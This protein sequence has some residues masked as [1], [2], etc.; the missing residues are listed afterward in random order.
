MSLERKRALRTQFMEWLYNATEGAEVEFADPADFVESAGSDPDEVA[1]AIRYLEGESLIE[2]LWSLGSGL[3]SAVRITH[4]GVREVEQALT[5][6][7]QPTQHFTPMVNITHIHGDVTGSQIQQGSP[8]ASQHGTFNFGPEQASQVAEFSRAAREALPKLGLDPMTEAR[9]VQDL[10]MLDR[11]VT[12][13]QPRIGIAREVAKSIRE[14]LE[15]A[16]GSA[17]GSGIVAGVI[18]VWPAFL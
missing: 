4:R 9:T 16:A 17:V 15:G 7:N 11:E 12:Q 6:P 13:P 8:G 5:N 2:P 14:V 1:G 3:P 18:A 10:D